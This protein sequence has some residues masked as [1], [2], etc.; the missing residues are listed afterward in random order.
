M[1]G[2]DSPGRNLF[3][4]LGFELGAGEKKSRPPLLAGAGCSLG[5]GNSFRIHCV[6]LFFLQGT[7]ILGRKGHMVSLRERSQSLTLEVKGYPLLKTGMSRAHVGSKGNW[8][9]Q[10]DVVERSPTFSISSEF[11]KVFNLSKPFSS[12]I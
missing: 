2:N 1:Y 12:V 4:H 7:G 9:G 11:R 8:E 3:L 6:A 5:L 10:C